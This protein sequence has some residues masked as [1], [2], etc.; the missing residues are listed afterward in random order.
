M[1]DDGHEGGGGHGRTRTARR[2]VADKTLRTSEHKR[3]DWMIVAFSRSLEVSKRG[4]EQLR[5]II[6]R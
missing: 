5:V 1:W 6:R 4:V 3:W 2:L